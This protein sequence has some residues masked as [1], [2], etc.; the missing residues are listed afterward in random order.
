MIFVPMVIDFAVHRGRVGAGDG[1]R[2]L[3]L[4]SSGGLC[5]LT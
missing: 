2:F 4:G 5:L 1:G 3:V